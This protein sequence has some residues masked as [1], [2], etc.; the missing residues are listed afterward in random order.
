MDPPQRTGVMIIRV[1][2]EPDHPRPLR[3]TLTSTVDVADGEETRRSAASV[4]T[5]CDGVREWL[6][7][8]L[9]PSA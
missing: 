8:F 9:E 5:V 4:E 3:A 1:W 7:E 6:E 2:L